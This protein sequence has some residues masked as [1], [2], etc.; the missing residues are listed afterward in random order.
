MAVSQLLCVCIVYSGTNCAGVH[1]A[2]AVAFVLPNSTVGKQSQARM[3]KGALE[4]ASRY[5]GTISA[6]CIGSRM[7][8][9][10]GKCS[11]EVHRCAS[12]LEMPRFKI[13]ESLAHTLFLQVSDVSFTTPGPS[14]ASEG[15]IVA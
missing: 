4:F 2:P 15:S 14:G 1:L 9:S 10:P 11:H 7:V 6:V 12:A 5:T 3:R 8:R 13:P